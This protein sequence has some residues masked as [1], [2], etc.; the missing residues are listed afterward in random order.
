M[1]PRPILAIALLLATALATT[2]C[3]KYQRHPPPEKQILGER[4]RPNVDSTDTRA[5]YVVDEALPDDRKPATPP[6]T[7]Y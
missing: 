1:T 6:A 4:P 5:H 7:T 2:A 3:A